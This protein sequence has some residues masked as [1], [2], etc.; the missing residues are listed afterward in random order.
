MHPAPASESPARHGDA[1]LRALSAYFLRLGA[2]GFGGPIALVGYMQR[3]LVEARRWLSPAE[4]A[5]GLAFCQLAPGPLAA[6]LAIYAGWLR[7]GARGATVVGAAF[8]LPS[9]VMV[10]LLSAFY[11]RLGGLPWM[12]AVFYGVSAGVIAIIVRSA[13]KLARTTVRGDWL[14]WPCFALNA[15]VTAVTS[16]ERIVVILACGVLVALVRGGPLRGASARPPVGGAAALLVPLAW[17]PA[18]A[19]TLHLQLFGFFAR[20]G[21]VVFGSGLAIVP[22][23][24][25]GTVVDHHWLTDRQFLDAVAV[26]MITPGPVVIT[27]AFI[28]YLVAGGA[29]AVVAALGVFLPVWLS[30]VALAP[31]FRRLST[32]PRVRAFVAGVTSATTGAI[33]GAVVVLGRRALVDPMAGVIAILALGVLLRF[34][35]VPEPVV[36]IAAGVVGLALAPG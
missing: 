9:F 31:S 16:S 20:A 5:E 23:L 24:Y 12:H 13:W 4:Y 36:I 19:G 6:Q 29:G 25:G 34:R 35:R 8:V 21:A 2:T 3:D 26:S 27:V 10:L 28:G 15:V 33:A 30:V 22:Y 1:T 11:V 18:A 14:L 17:P 32:D 7:H